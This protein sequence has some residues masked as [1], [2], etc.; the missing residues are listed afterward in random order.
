MSKSSRSRPGVRRPPF[1]G[2][3][4]PAPPSEE[5][6]LTQQ[7]EARKALRSNL[8]ALI[9][10]LEFYLSDACSQGRTDADTAFA[11]DDLTKARSD[12]RDAQERLL[13]VLLTFVS[14]QR[15]AAARHFGDDPD[16]EP[17]IVVAPP[18]ALD[19]LGKHEAHR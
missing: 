5:D 2:G 7:L 17:N 6:R 19:H 1:S 16:A 18:D 12:L 4:P 13:G 11:L 15:I 14:T 3:R 8:Q 9:A 10:E